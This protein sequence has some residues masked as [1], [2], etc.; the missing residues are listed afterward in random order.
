MQESI[1]NRYYFTFGTDPVYPYRGGWV[2]VVAKDINKAIEIF[3]SHY[4]LI[5]N[6]T[7]RYAFV[8]S[9]SDFKQTVMYLK[10]NFGYGCHKVHKRKAKN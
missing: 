4:P 8:Y 9:E 6:Q 10:G 5:D 2:E 1:N 7:G 3:N